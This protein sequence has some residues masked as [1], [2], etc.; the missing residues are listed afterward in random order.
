MRK[1]MAGDAAA[2]ARIQ[3]IGKAVTFPSALAA[4]VFAVLSFK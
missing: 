2:N 1:A 4:L 3:F